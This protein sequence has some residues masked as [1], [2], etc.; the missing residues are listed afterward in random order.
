M[1]IIEKY[2]DMYPDSPYLLPIIQDPKQDEYRQY[3]KMLRLH[4]YRLRQVG[5]FPEN[6]GAV[7][8]LRGSPY[9]GNDGITTEL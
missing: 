3:S 7:E 4:N 9:L 5:I 1:A 6:Q 2:K 8:Y